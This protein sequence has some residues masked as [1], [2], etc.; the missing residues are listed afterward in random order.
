MTLN[1]QY[2]IDIPETSD[3]KNEDPSHWCKER[4]DDHWYYV[5]YYGWRRYY[6]ERQ[7]DAAAFTIRWQ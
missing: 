6:F 3:W 5:S 2:H 4:F 7:E 1:Y